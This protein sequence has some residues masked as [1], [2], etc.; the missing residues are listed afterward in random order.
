VLVEFVALAR[1][2]Q[3]GDQQ[4]HRLG[5]PQVPQQVGRLVHHDARP[6]LLGLGHLPDVGVLVLVK[7][8]HRIDRRLADAH[9]AQAA[10]LEDVGAPAG[11]EQPLDQRRHRLRVAQLGQPQGG[12]LVQQE[13][14]LVGRGGHQL[15][16][17]GHRLLVADL[18]HRPDGGQLGGVGPGLD[19]QRLLGRLD[20]LVDRIRRLHLPQHTGGDHR[21][22][23]LLVGVVQGLDQQRFGPIVLVAGQRLQVLGAVALLVEGDQLGH[24]HPGLLHVHVGDPVE[25]LFLV[26]QIAQLLCP[27]A[28]VVGIS[29]AGDQSQ[30]Q[31]GA[32][33]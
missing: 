16:Q 22:V 9:Q 7:L 4:R 23:E 25:R 27:G 33:Q 31:K 32:V 1:L 5:R 2:R 15:D 21:P 28:G 6:E 20:Q 26:A 12:P 13:V 19:R 8:D 14:L 18:H 10:L 17:R 29:R 3:A 11:H 30:D 24:D